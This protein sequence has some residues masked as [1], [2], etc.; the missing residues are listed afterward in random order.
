[1]TMR[2]TGGG[3]GGEAGVPPDILDFTEKLFLIAV[4]DLNEILEA[5]REGRLEMAREGK[6]AVRDL[7]EMGKQVILERNNVDQLRK[8]AAGAAG[9]GGELD[10]AAARDEIGR[11]LA[12]LRAAR[13]D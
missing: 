6:R 1:M 5:I 12:C 9:A 10:L 7:A 11:R 4:E 13:G 8:R 2:F 3:S